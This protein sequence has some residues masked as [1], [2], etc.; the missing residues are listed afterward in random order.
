[1]KFFITGGAG[2]IGSTLIRHIINNT[3]FDVINI[4]SLTY[5]GNIESL[6]DIR[7]SSRYIFEEVDICDRK[8]LNKLFKKH[9][10]NIIMHLDAE[11]QEYRS[12]YGPLKF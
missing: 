5:A 7:C 8:A 12:I 10:P 2:F 4:D 11:S 1:M 9:N 6:S 3:S